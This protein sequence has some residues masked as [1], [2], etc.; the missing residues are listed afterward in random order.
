[1]SESKNTDTEPPSAGSLSDALSPRE[2]TVLAMASNGLT[3]RAIGADL[4]I[5][6]ATVNTYWGRIRAKIGGGTRSELVAIYVRSLA[7][8]ELERHAQSNKSLKA[9]LESH[10]VSEEDLRRANE[11]LED[12][13][14]KSAGEVSA[15]AQQGFFVNQGLQ[16][17]FE[18]CQNPCAVVVDSKF[19]RVNDAWKSSLGY[20]D[21]DLI[22]KEWQSFCHPDDLARIIKT[23]DEVHAGD[24]GDVTGRTRDSKGVYRALRW[25]IIFNPYTRES[26]TIAVFLEPDELAAVNMKT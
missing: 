2:T 20:T 22:G 13:L 3:D 21:E 8:S 7:S 12:L 26:L 25:Y 14:S 5:S 10:L 6:V 18:H 11:R 1:M 19:V 23:R 24:T 15:T 17:M 16:F 9:Q 4:G